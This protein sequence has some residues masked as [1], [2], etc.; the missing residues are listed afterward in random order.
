[1]TTTIRNVLIDLAKWY[2][3]GIKIRELYMRSY[4]LPKDAGLEQRG[5]RAVD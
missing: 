5:I 1:M 2:M 4:Y 3:L